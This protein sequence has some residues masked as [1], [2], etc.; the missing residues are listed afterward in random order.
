MIARI[1]AVEEEFPSTSVG[2]L[3]QREYDFD[4][5]QEL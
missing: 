1:I 3:P 5:N 2:L 4:N